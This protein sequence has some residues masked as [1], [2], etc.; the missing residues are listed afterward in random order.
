MG[1]AIN[2]CISVNA[3]KLHWHNGVPPQLMDKTY[4][5]GWYHSEGYMVY[6][7]AI[8]YNRQLTVDVSKKDLSRNLKPCIYRTYYGHGNHIG[9]YYAISGWSGKN[10]KTPYACWVQV[11]HDKSKISITQPAPLAK[12]NHMKNINVI[13]WHTLHRTKNGTQNPPFYQEMIHSDMI[14]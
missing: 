11:Y 12:I 4:W 8:F 13:S 9:H 3:A 2:G 6:R 7:S 5:T 14:L 10:H 1:G